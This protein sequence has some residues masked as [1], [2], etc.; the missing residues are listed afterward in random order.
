MDM[1][2][3]AVLDTRVFQA[4]GLKETQTSEMGAV[5]QLVSPGDVD[6]PQ[7]RKDVD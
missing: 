2:A 3:A 7:L 5:G 1:A 4:S 6:Q